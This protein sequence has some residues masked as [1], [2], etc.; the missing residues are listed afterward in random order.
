MK[1][2]ATT[3]ERVNAA[4]TTARA[5][6]LTESEATAANTKDAIANA[7]KH[8]QYEILCEAAKIISDR[9]YMIDNV[10]MSEEGW[11]IL[12]RASHESYVRL[13]IKRRQLLNMAAAYNTSANLLY[14]IATKL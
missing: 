14:E 12:N 9:A 11:N 10:V 13:T 3:R 8:G 4:V 1:T 2:N 6:T 7:I 5:N